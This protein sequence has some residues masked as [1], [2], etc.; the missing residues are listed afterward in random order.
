MGV[1]VCTGGDAMKLSIKRV[2]EPVT[3]DDGTRILVDRLWPRGV[4]KVAAHLDLWLKD[5][6]PS[7]ALRQGYHQGRVPW[8]EFQSRYVAELSQKTTEL[9][10]IRLALQQGAV[11][12][13]YAAKDALQNHA[14]VLQHFL[15]HRFR[16]AIESHDD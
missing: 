14:I 8:G 9:E 10:P 1:F 4:T 2:Y 12:L 6:A 5:A 11:T 7:P 3:A 13:V 16:D 15:E